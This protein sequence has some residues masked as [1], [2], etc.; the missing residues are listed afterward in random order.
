[1][2]KTVRLFCALLPI[3]ASA[4]AYGLDAYFFTYDKSNWNINANDA[5]NWTQLS[6][7]FSG[8]DA[9][10]YLFKESVDE[11]TVKANKGKFRAFY[12]SGSQS[13]TVPSAS[14]DVY[15]ARFGFAGDDGSAPT[16]ITSCS[17]VKFTSGFV[18]NNMY[19]RNHGTAKFNFTGG[20]V[21]LNV[22]N[23]TIGYTT[24]AYFIKTNAGDVA[25]ISVAGKLAYNGGDGIFS[26]GTASSFFDEVSIGSFTN[27]IGKD[28]TKFSI[29][30]KK[31]T[32]GATSF[33]RAD[34]GYG[35]DVTLFIGD[36]IEG[37]TVYSLGETIK[38]AERKITLDFSALDAESLANGDYGILEI[39]AASTGFT[40]VLAE[41][42][43]IV[44]LA[45]GTLSWNGSN[46]TLSV[47][48]EPAEVAALLGVVALAF[49]AYRR[50]RG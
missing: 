26:I 33:V 14:S 29:A 10:T 23:L 5:T 39:S 34:K 20:D 50:R 25:K 43:D 44:G 22:N 11:A 24:N 47:V 7:Q 9:D 13:G 17:D 18:A 2:N 41:D 42:F 46:L 31:F 21:S 36:V 45:G 38:A 15:F 1:M 16:S 49:A 32:S 28:G 35:M 12:I 6:K 37:D 3:A 4:Y 30:A 8:D 19:T 40:G 48:P 27:S